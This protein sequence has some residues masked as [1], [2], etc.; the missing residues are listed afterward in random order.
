MFKV[1]LPILFALG[2]TGCSSLTDDLDDLGG[3]RQSAEFAIPLVDSEV[4][5]TDLLGS[6]DERF[7]LTVDPDGLL[8]FRYSDTVPPVTSETIF[9]DLRELGRGIPLPIT[10]RD[11]RLPFPLPNR[12]SIDLARL[13]AGRLT[14]VLPNPYDQPVR[15]TL[16]LTNFLNNDAVATITGELP[17]YSGSGDRPT[18]TNAGAPLDLA[19]YVLNFSD[20]E[21]RIEYSIDALDGT[22]LKPGPGTVLLLS[23]LEFSY[24]EGYFGQLPYPG[25]D[26][27][28][29]IDFFENYLSGD[30][31]FVDPRIVVQVRSSVG[32]PA[33]AVVES[34]N[35]ETADGRRI[36]V[37]G[38]IVDEGFRFDYPREPGD[39]ATTTYVVDKEN[40]NLLDL[41]EARPVALNYRISAQINPDADPT[42]TGFLSDTNSYA[43]TVT[44]ELPLYGSARDFEVTDTLPVN[45]GEQYGEVTAATFRVTT[46]SDLPLDLL[47]SG[48]FVDSLGSPVAD[49]T[50]GELLIMEASETDPSGTPLGTVRATNDIPITGEALTRIRQARSLVLTTSF[51][52]LDGGTRPVRITNEQTLRV[53]IGARLTL[54]QP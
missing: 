36:P 13:G 16:R 27:Q 47:L 34:L 19:G 48:T 45:L 25:V 44:L 41:L 17:A 28:L 5:L 35:V 43:A 33:R 50:D 51:A 38:E 8:R 49:L 32:V 29:A 6:V 39:N 9:A 3:V 10:E 2:A 1:L 22:P 54:E 52:T 24:L 20:E 18:L 14:Y 30:V 7:L 26:D 4:D 53:R 31:T 15:L 46:D 37:E 21:L 40:S 12:A 42:Q 11:T 23:D